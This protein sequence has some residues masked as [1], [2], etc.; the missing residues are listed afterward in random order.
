MKGI[1]RRLKS[2]LLNRPKQ[3]V[4]ILAFGFVLGCLLMTFGQLDSI[5]N[6]SLNQMKDK[7]EIKINLSC[8]R[9]VYYSSEYLTYLQE[10]VKRNEQD[11]AVK[12]VNQKMLLTYI[13]DR[14]EDSYTSGDILAISNDSYLEEYGINLLYGRFF[15]DSDYQGSSHTILVADHTGYTIGD[16]LDF[17]L[18]GEMVQFEVIGRYQKYD[19]NYDFSMNDSVFH[20][21]Y[22]YIIPFSCALDI[23]E[24]EIEVGKA[25]ATMDDIEIILNDSLEFQR[26]YRE[27]REVCG[28]INEGL[29][30][31]ISKTPH[32]FCVLTSNMNDVE[33]TLKPIRNLKKLV[34][35]VILTMSILTY[36]IFNLIMVLF[37]RK[38]KK[39]IAILMSL[40]E[41]KINLFL[42]FI[43]E[44]L[45][46]CLIG[47]M[48]A[49][50]FSFLL[51]PQ[52]IRVMIDANL[53][54]QKELS[55]IGHVLKNFDFESQKQLLIGAY[56]SQSKIR[57]IL[58]SG[59][60][61]CTLGS[62]TVAVIMGIL[63][64][65]NPRKLYQREE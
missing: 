65:L 40:G 29:S 62:G 49:A 53:S 3:N 38:R 41:S 48:I 12:Q 37:M 7:L 8:E 21:A 25:N 63:T 9:A 51:T 33:T 52:M 44:T 26:I 59:G 36:S 46:L 22:D 54:Y 28:K 31:G 39:E 30:L 5:L 35:Y 58:Y 57:S 13:V 60:I 24:D 45:I 16:I 42:Q 56:Q 64:N 18:G 19:A 47:S 14:D 61:I 43:I 17:E 4:L 32:D 50:I 11:P 27:N 10:T 23:L 1:T 15:D 6:Y 20:R 34:S 2:A 55:R